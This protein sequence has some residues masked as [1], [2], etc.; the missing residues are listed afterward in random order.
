MEKQSKSTSQ[1][2]KKT[3]AFAILVLVLIMQP[4]YWVYARHNGVTQINTVT[5]IVQKWGNI[6]FG[7]LLVIPF[8][9]Q[10]F[11]YFKAKFFN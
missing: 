7:L 11:K 6:I 2:L 1:K 4:N 10:G 3:I 9:I 8:L 5:D